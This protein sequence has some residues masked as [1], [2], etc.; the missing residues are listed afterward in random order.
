MANRKEIFIKAIGKIGPPPEIFFIHAK[1]NSISD[2]ELGVEFMWTNSWATS[3]C[4][5]QFSQVLVS[6]QTQIVDI[7]GVLATLDTSKSGMTIELTARRLYPYTL[8]L[9]A[10]KIQIYC[11][12]T[13]C[14]LGYEGRS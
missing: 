8:S 10:Y 12:Q 14:Y 7:I 9:F 6:D 13:P 11:D 1:I 4:G 3:R 5:H 2:Q